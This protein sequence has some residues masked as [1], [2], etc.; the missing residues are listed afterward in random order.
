MIA[1]ICR[2]NKTLIPTLFSHLLL[3]GL[4]RPS[5]HIATCVPMLK[6]GGRDA[7][8]PKN[9]PPISRISCLAKTVEKILAD[10]T[11]VAAH[12]TGAITNEQ[13]EY[14]AHRS[15]MDALLLNLT[16]AQSWLRDVSSYKKPGTR[17]SLVAN[18]IDGAFNCVLHDPLTFILRHYGF[19][20]WLVKTIGSYSSHRRIYMAFDG[21]EEERLPFLVGLPQGSPQS[22]I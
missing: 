5:W 15:S 21:E 20:E 19:P 4:F 10:R 12:E 17:P 8:I 11:A 22:P 6:P 18:D 3:H 7:S 14:L 13:F 9:L 2:V 1:A 16:K